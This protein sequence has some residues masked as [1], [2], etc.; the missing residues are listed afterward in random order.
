MPVTGSSTGYVAQVVKGRRFGAVRFD[1]VRHDLGQLLDGLASADPEVRDGWAYREL[2]EAIES[3]RFDQDRQR[4][5]QAALDHLDSVQVQARTFAP[6][7]LTWL[8]D[9]GDRDRAAFETVA[10]WYPAELDTRG[11]DEQLGWLHAVAH[12]ADYLSRCVK[13]NV[14]SGPEVLELLAARLV[15][16]GPAWRDQEDARVARAAVIALTSCTRQQAAGWLG[17]VNA[18]MDDFEQSEPTGRP[19]AWINNTYA[20]CTSLYVALSEQPRDGNKNVHV[21]GADIVRDALARTISRIT[22][23]LLT[24]RIDRH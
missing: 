10:R 21:D 8:I 14:A 23:W 4:I 7:V 5:R 11:Y 9:A 2:R 24:P 1:A 12:G 6:L 17:P 19:P 3:G 22:P 13:A 15:G 16:P 18:A 20:T